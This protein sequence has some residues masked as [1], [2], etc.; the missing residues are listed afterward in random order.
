M[1]MAVCIWVQRWSTAATFLAQF[2]GHSAISLHGQ[3]QSRNSVKAFLCI[4]FCGPTC[5]TTAVTGGFRS[6]TP[7]S[8]SVDDFFSQYGRVNWLPDA[9][10]VG[11]HCTHHWVFA[12]HSRKLWFVLLRFRNK[13]IGTYLLI[14]ELLRYH[15]SLRVSFQQGQEL[16]APQ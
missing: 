2:T 16:F 13:A 3:E 1:R 15:S 5:T 11:N 9:V 7:K 8:W 14:L 12:E 6:W 10:N 4:S